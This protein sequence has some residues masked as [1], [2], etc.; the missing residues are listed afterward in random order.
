MTEETS[1]EYQETDSDNH[2]PGDHPSLVRVAGLRRSVNRA[3]NGRHD[4]ADRHYAN[5]ELLGKVPG[6]A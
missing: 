3:A 1:E 4:A 6:R 5:A 2:K